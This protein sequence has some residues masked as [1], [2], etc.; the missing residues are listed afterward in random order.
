MGR[1]ETGRSE[2]FSPSRWARALLPLLA[3]LLLS[4][5]AA[6]EVGVAP[7]S[8]PAA[9]LL[10]AG[11]L[12]GVICAAT[13]RCRVFGRL[14]Q[15]AGIDR[16]HALCAL[17][18][19]ALAFIVCDIASYFA[20]LALGEMAW[21]LR[22]VSFFS[23][24]S[25]VSLVY[26]AALVVLPFALSAEVVTSLAGACRVRAQD[27]FLFRGGLKPPVLFLLFASGVLLRFACSHVQSAPFPV[28]ASSLA[29]AAVSTFLVLGA[30]L[31]V[32]LLL[33]RWLAGRQKADR[34]MAPYCC[35]VIGL[36]WFSAG[37]MAHWM[38]F[39]V[40]PVARAFSGSPVG[41]ATLALLAG[42]A[43]LMAGMGLLARFPGADSGHAVH[44][45][46]DEALSALGVDFTERE[47]EIA[48]RTLEGGSSTKIGDDLGISSST[49]R[50]VQ[51]RIY[52]KTKSSSRSDFMGKFS[53]ANGAKRI[54]GASDKTGRSTF[55]VAKPVLPFVVFAGSFLPLLVGELFPSA[56]WGFWRPLV[57][58]AALLSLF[59]FLAEIHPDCLKGSRGSSCASCA[60]S[61]AG[62][63]MV[64]FAMG[65]LLGF[66][67][68]ELFRKIAYT[69]FFDS[70]TV[71]LSILGLAGAVRMVQS[72]RW[73]D[74][75]ACALLTAISS[76]LGGAAAMY[77]FACCGLYGLLS[78]S[79]V[80]P[81]P[82]RAVAAGG[83]FGMVLGDY[84]I[85]VVGDLLMGNEVVVAPL[86]GAGGLHVLTSAAVAVT[87]CVGVASALFCM[88]RRRRVM[89]SKTPLSGTQDARGA[90]RRY[91]SACGLNPTQC[92]VLLL[93]AEGRTSSQISA[94]LLCSA[95]TVNSARRDGYAILGIH[96][97]AQLKDLLS[98]QLNT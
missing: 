10:G 71:S 81:A 48:A 65:V 85:N 84:A 62:P 47:R 8:S 53:A 66:A 40:V 38:L 9:L 17:G 44:A 24:I 82:W 69:S 96:S 32:A 27:A 76:L 56:P 97:K 20:M 50:S 46:L 52:A 86:G 11:T 22:G 54:S 91:L 51:Q 77:A 72:R 13:G 95:G 61:L 2:G 31:A 19:A 4:P 14:L 34:E 73:L 83:G 74:G 26:Y 93:V 60:S 89:S 12:A 92:D 68:E 88:V 23:S 15:R 39:R 80:S 7:F 75:V 36:L 3:L 5:S 18:V 30:G 41:G 6:G 64:A 78:D 37:L 33:P 25:W 94:K 55:S 28:D 29:G 49:V 57:Y 58:L 1:K 90:A 87:S 79:Y 59:V 70:L 45:G 21:P 16:Q 63:V 98:S 35:C 43:C 67:A 42:M